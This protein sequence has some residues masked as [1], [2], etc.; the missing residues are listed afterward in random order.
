MEDRWQEIS[1]PCIIHG[2]AGTYTRK[3]QSS[4]L[5]ISVKG[6]LSRTFDANILPLA[7]ILKEIR[8]YEDDANTANEIWEHIVHQLNGLYEGKHQEV[9][10]DGHEWPEDSDAARRA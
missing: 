7:T 10:K 3:G 8:S 5:V 1:Y 4:I 9:D 6:I 2:D